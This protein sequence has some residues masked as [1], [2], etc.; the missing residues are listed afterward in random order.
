[1][2]VNHTCICIGVLGLTATHPKNA[3]YDWIAPWRI[4]LDDFAGAASIF[5]DSAG[6]CM[7]ANFFFD[8]QFAQ[9]SATAA[10]LIAETK[11]GRGYWIDRHQVTAIENG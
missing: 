11:L 2:N 5:E 7:I 10:G 4:W 1:M 9:W 6:R 8:L 3:R